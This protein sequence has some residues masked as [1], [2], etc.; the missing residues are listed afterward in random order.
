MA[1]L[2]SRVESSRIVW[3]TAIARS[4]LWAVETALVEAPYESRPAQSQA[5]KEIDRLES[6]RSLNRALQNT[7]L[8]AENEYLELKRRSAPEGG[9]N[10]GAESRGRYLKQ[11]RREN[12]NSQ[13]IN[14]IGICE[15][16]R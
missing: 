13:F 6:V 10:S 8:A 12:R 4:R 9:K 1:P 15:N 16:H 3:S 5:H 2:A 11:Y 14:Q 7:D